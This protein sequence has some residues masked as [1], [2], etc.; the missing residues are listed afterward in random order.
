[1]GD[2]TKGIESG[3]VATIFVSI[4]LLV[5]QM[6]GLAPEFALI[7]WLNY[8]AGTEMQPAMGWLL[9]FIIVG[10]SSSVYAGEYV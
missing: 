7:H 10:K 5:Q 4:L 2:I 1:M 9:H 3:F 6:S 8:A